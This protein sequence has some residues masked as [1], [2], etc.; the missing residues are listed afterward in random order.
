MFIKAL[1]TFLT[2]TKTIQYLFRYIY[3]SKLH[4]CSFLK[5]E[6]QVVGLLFLFHF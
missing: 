2:P 4:L 3:T 6:I 5:E 1:K